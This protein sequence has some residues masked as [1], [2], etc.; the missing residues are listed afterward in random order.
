MYQP[1]KDNVKEGDK[2]EKPI[3]ELNDNDKRLIALDVKARAAIGNALAYDIY[4]FVQNCI[5]AKVMMDTLTVVYE[6]TN[7]VKVVNK[8][9][10]NRK[11]WALFPIEKWISHSGF[12]SL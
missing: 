6:G 11:V 8:N 1:M 3:H 9:N 12:Q 2:V 4:H 10:L 5:S 7:E